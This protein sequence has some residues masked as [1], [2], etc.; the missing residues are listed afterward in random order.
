MTETLRSTNNTTTTLYIPFVG[1]QYTEDNIREVFAFNNI[2]PIYSITLLEHNY[3]IGTIE[4]GSVEGDWGRPAFIVIDHILET[5]AN[6]ND[7]F[8][9]IMNFGRYYVDVEGPDGDF[10]LIQLYQQEQYQGQDQEPGQDQDQE[11]EQ[12]QEQN[13]NTTSSS[14]SSSADEIIIETGSIITNEEYE[15]K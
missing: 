2:G 15:T 10:W 14:S 4:M 12:D 5:N 13:N 6:L 11:Q 9:H 7:I 1:E 3:M 8:N